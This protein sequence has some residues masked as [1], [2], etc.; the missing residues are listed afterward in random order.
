MQIELVPTAPE[1]TPLIAN[2]YQFYLY[3]SSD[4]EQEDVDTA[5]GGR[6]VDGHC[7]SVRNR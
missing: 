5:V 7:L 1:Q 4:W 6:V 2:L 3:E